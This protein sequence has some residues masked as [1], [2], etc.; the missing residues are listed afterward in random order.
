[1]KHHFPRIFLLFVI[2]LRL[3]SSNAQTGFSDS[4]QIDSAEKYWQAQKD[5]TNKVNSLNDLSSQLSE[6]GDL[7]NA[8]HFAKEALRISEQIKF[9]KGEAN[10]LSNVV[11]AMGEQDQSLYPEMYRLLF[12]AL[13]LFEEQKDKKGIALCYESMAALRYNEGN[14][15]EALKNNYTALRLYE[16]LGDVKSL[17]LIY[18]K[19]AYV[20]DA[21]N[22]INDALKNYQSSLHFNLQ[23]SDSTRV[24][25]NYMNIGRMYFI[26]GN[27]GEALKMQ[28]SALEILKRIEGNHTI[29][30]AY[31]N[32]GNIYVKEGEIALA[33][34]DK[35]TSKKK[36]SA[37]LENYLISLKMLK[38]INSIDGLAELYGL[39][40]N[41]YIKLNA[42]KLAR[43]YLEKSL[44]SSLAIGYNEQIKNAYFTLAGLDS[45]EGNYK[46][47]YDHYKAYIALRDT[48]ANKESTRKS[49]E[50]KLQYEFDKKAAIAKAAQDKKDAEAKRVK[51]IQYFTIAALGI[52]VLAVIII[53]TIQYRNNK[54]KQK[55]NALLQQQ[56]AKVE[57][58]LSEL[59]STQAQLIQSEKMASLGQLTAGIAHEIQNPLNFVNNFSEVSNELIDEMN[60][61]LEKGEIVE[62]KL[63]AGDIKQNLEKINHHG[64]RADAI[65]KG[66]LQHSRASTGQKEPADINKF[67]DEFLQLAFQGFR[68]KTPDFNAEIK[69]D[70][71][72]SIG[73]VRI[74]S[75]DIG[76]VLVNLYNNSFYAMNE[77]A[78]LSPN[79]YKPSVKL[80]TK[81]LK[82]KVE[83]RVEDNGGGVPKNI[84]D[85]IFQPFFTTKPTGQGTGLGL[86]LAYDIIKA[87]GGEIR[88]STKEGEG[89]EFIIQLPAY[90]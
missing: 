21:Q 73:N 5:D 78:K 10:A 49:V 82:D 16:Q 42:L 17:A 64:K 26:Q 86:S 18:T 54:Q 51:N 89:I 28:F 25:G 27:Y 47:A 85:K 84:I 20:Y 34:G 37:A 12:K 48:L 46:Q 45:L 52:V 87:H 33:D 76:R 36:L 32:I 88:V 24:A 75:Q 39:L 7:D 11:S 29:P 13:Q 55:A 3:Y 35:A 31:E 44:Q 60:G 50:A 83:I 22:N 59:R 43:S 9:K 23:L 62:A 8:L 80:T 66:M 4:L 90:A 69:T 40:G 63:I 30:Y 6:R 71:D 56:K 41:L 15:A 68:A 67:A 38:E 1:M 70:F 72:D 14:Y 79:N 74:V 2:T 58:T 57:S 19:I 77:K 61:E 81:K 65:V 53:A